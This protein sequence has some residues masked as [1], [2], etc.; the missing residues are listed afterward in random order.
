MITEAQKKM[1]EYND[2]QVKNYKRNR[3]IRINKEI[4][5]KEEVL[6]RRERTVERE[7]KKIRLHDYWITHIEYD[8][9]TE[10]QIEREVQFWFD[11]FKHK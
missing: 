8:E 10:E 5:Y 11:N 4:K 6:L 9:L 3:A 1:L 7:P 2:I